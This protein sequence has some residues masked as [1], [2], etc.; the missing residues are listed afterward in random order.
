MRLRKVRGAR[1]QLMKSWYIVKDPCSYRGKYK[2]LF[3]NNNPLHLEIGCGKGQF[4]LEMAKLNPHL[5]F[6]GIEK[7]DSVLCRALPKEDYPNLFFI[8]GD[9][10]N[11]ETFFD[12]EIDLLY[13]NFSDPWPKRRHTHRRLTSNEFLRR[14]QSLFSSYPHIIM[15]T[16]NRSFFEFSLK[17]LI[18]NDYKIIKISL[19]LHADNYPFNI[20]TEYEEK[21]VAKGSVIYMVEVKKR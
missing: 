18:D 16:D 20:M 8:S 11:I 14:Y 2:E 1:E 10:I 5:N 3:K 17:T 9:A 7:Y 4:L 21:F 12:N 13:L 15:K 19:D 6:L